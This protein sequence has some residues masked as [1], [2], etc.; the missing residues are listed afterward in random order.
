MPASSCITFAL[1]LINIRNG[2]A[3]NYVV[4][5]LEEVKAVPFVLGVMLQVWAMFQSEPSSGLFWFSFRC[6]TKCQG[7]SKNSRSHQLLQ[8]RVST[9]HEFSV[10]I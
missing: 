5:L 8:E 6:Y 9:A 2:T 1:H 10:G 4:P 3:L 7:S